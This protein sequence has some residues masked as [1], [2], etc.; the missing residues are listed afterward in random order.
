MSRKPI[1]KFAVLFFII[2]V[3]IP[4][5][6]VLVLAEGGQATTYYIP[7]TVKSEFCNVPSAGYPSIQS[8]VDEDCTTITLTAALYTENIFLEDRSVV[9]KG[10]GPANTTIDGN[11]NGS[12]FI[13]EVNSALTLEGVT[14]TNGS[15]SIAGAGIRNLGT[16]RL[17]NTVV[18]ENNVSSAKGGGI[19]SLDTLTVENSWIINNSSSTEGGGVF[20]Y[21]TAHFTNT[22]ISGNVADEGG[23]VAVEGDNAVAT[24][25]NTQI[26]DNEA[27]IGG[28]IWF[29]S[30]PTSSI[31]NSLIS[32]NRASEAG[33]A[34]MNGGNLQIFGSR[35]TGNSTGKNGGLGICGGGII[36]SGG[37]YLSSDRGVL[38]IDS[39]EIR[40]NYSAQDGG[41][42]CNLSGFGSVEAEIE[43]YNSLIVDNT[44]DDGGGFYSESDD[45]AVIE[46]ST[47]V[48][49]NSISQGGGISASNLQL[50]NVTVSQNE[51]PNGA[52]IYSS[53]EVKYV[54]TIVAGNLSGGDCSAGPSA[55]LTSLGHNI[56]SDNSC[57]LNGPGDMANINPLLGPLQNNGGP[58][59]TT[60][61]PSNSPAKD[62]ADNAACPPTDQRGVI[63][64]QGAGCDMGAYE[65][66]G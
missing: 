61:I 47:V 27:E 18:K 64:P 16:T 28:G 40:G 34:I 62:S 39:T 11:A 59:H 35:I 65:Y 57:D 66:N 21:D 3:S 10:Q 50:V 51:S 54:N 22:V 32:N 20:L 55:D 29:T 52:G 24:F 15:S 19:F 45:L 26:L 49:N 37:A 44:A 31:Y 38:L 9:I 6:N 25:V 36:N 30:N 12:V 5:L 43:V 14:V 8:A 60:A 7:L 4:G 53:G 17:F 1:Y 58:T 13:V 46:N 41:G 56:A 23:G 2:L 48:N 33:G 63:R 42:I